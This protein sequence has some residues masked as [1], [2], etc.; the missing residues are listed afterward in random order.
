MTQRVQTVAV[1]PFK[2]CIPRTNVQVHLLTDTIILLERCARPDVAKT[3][4]DPL[5]A[6]Q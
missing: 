1:R 3:V 6:M 4:E 5:N 2:I